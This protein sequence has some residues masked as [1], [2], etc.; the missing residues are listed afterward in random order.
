MV[1]GYRRVAQT[2]AKHA[3]G[4]A[5]LVEAAAELKGVDERPLPTYR[6]AVRNGPIAQLVE[7]RTFNP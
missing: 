1:N 7:L 2:V 3:R 4:L 5:P 6:K